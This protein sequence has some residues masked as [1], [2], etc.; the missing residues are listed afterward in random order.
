MNSPGPLANADLL[1]TNATLLT[2]RPGEGEAFVGHMVVDE[3]GRIAGIAAGSPPV[4]TTARRMLDAT[5]KI[6][7]PGF[8]SAHSHLFQSALRGV[9]ADLNTGE[10]RKAMH[11]YS[12]PATDDDLYWFTLHGALGHLLHG[13]TSVFN[14]GYNARFG[15]YNVP[16]LRGL[17]DSD[18][19]FVHAFAQNRSAQSTS[20]TRASCATLMLQNHTWA[21]H[22][23]C[24]SA[25]VV[26]AVRSSM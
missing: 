21:I 17:L 25:L 15:E 23:S 18:M 20:N 10:W 22:G 8:V 14:F 12:V 19:R 16:Q 7:I 24:A 9:G 4:G 6:V 5:G 1:V 2:M 26:M 13:V 3:V 11:V